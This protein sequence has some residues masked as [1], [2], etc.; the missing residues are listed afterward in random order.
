MTKVFLD[1]SDKIYP[2]MVAQFYANLRIKDLGPK[3]V[4]FSQVNRVKMMLNYPLFNTIFGTTLDD[5]TATVRYWDESQ[6]WPAHE[7][8]FQLPS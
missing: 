8:R 6:Q 5:P 4:L 7:P 2:G 3:S 1:N